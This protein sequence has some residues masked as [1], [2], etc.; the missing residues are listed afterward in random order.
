MLAFSP[1]T[2]T[3]YNIVLTALSLVAAI[4]L[5]GAGLAIAVEPGLVAS[6]WIGGAIVGGGIAA[7]HYTG[8]AAFEIP[9][10]IVWDPLLVAVSIALGAVLGAVSLRTGLAGNSMK[11]RVYGALLLT[12]AICSH[13]FTAMGAISILPDPAIEISKSSLPTSW[14][15]VAVATASVIIIV[16]AFAGLTL[17]FQQRRS[18]LEAEWMRRLAN[19]SVEALIVCNGD[20]IVTVNNSF[21]TLV[22][23][24]EALGARL[25][26]YL[27]DE[28]SRRTL[29]ERPN[30]PFE[31]GLLHSNGS[32]IPVEAILRVIDFAGMPHQAIAIRDL[33]ARKEA[34]HRVEQAER[35]LATVIDKAPVPIV[36]K[37]PATQKFVLVNRAYEQFA[38][39]CRVE[40]IGKTVHDLYPPLQAKEI[41]ELDEHAIQ[42]GREI[43]RELALDTV[44]GFHLA[45]TTRIV[46]RDKND[47]PQHLILAIEDVT[48]RARVEEKLR[49]QKLLTETAVSNMSQG[50]VMFDPQHR[51]VLCNSRY[52]EIY[53]MNPEVVR[54][55][56]T[57][58]E[59][60]DHRKEIG[61]FS[62]DPEKRARDIVA[63]VVQGQAWTEVLTLPNLRSIQKNTQP[64]PGGGWVA[65]HEDIT[66]RQLA[67]ERIKYMAHHDALTGLPNRTLLREQLD[68]HLSS[69][70]RGATLAIL[71]LDLDYFK[72]VND[73]LGHPIGDVLLCAVGKRLSECIRDS[74]FVA[75]LGGDE[76]AII[77]TD[78][79]QPTSASALAQRLVD[80]MATPFD[81]DGH[82]IIIGT[83]VGISIAP[84]DSMDPDILLK[85]ADMA[86]YRAKEHGRN[87]FSFFEAGMDTKM[88]ER[89][90]LEIDLRKAIAVGEF[91]LF[92]QPIMNLEHDTISGFEALLR[93]NHPTRGMVTPATFI[94]LAEDTGL[95]IPIGEWVLRQAC[96]EAAKWPDDIKVAVNL[97]PVQFRNRNLVS[98]V[99]SAVANSGIAAS[100]LELEITETIMLQ[101]SDATLAVLR[102]LKS[103]G[104]RISMD[105][106]GTGYSSLSYL[107]SFPFDKIK[108]DQCFVRDLD[109]GGEAIAIIHAVSGLGKSFGMMTTVE[110]IET[111]D[112]LER[113]RSEGCTEVQGYLFGKPQPASEVPRLL[114]GLGR[115]SQAAA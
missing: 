7:M 102:M 77:Q 22:G 62:G 107:R 78:V 33:R 2:P 110:G 31:A 47:K 3:A 40:L 71:C 12:A 93:W 73:T 30:Q 106:F 63:S 55:G 99:T 111:K 66:E 48:E 10:R 20:V 81:A 83:S 41:A 58:Q 19:V 26:K 45:K 90:T 101:N 68:Y 51:I 87:G 70:K 65:T 5:T 15:A 14:L 18:K 75:R 105:D 91:E 92:Y 82:E 25:E 4:L 97:S 104:V 13:H 44:G 112:Q 114:S 94:P 16:F 115:K 61:L 80:T 59:L 72:Q 54:P 57:L 37:D 50:L 96:T 95:I 52:I 8:M 69:V 38:G 85:S 24:E 76:F 46:V 39:K 1:G 56:C 103:L 23:D 49:E 43:S 36:V 108:I 60:N 79:E 89:R 88:H 28:T 35:F 34:E 84:N 74:D 53:N 109:K 27:P 9:G 6:A 100:R 32:I 98:I 17:D 29:L 11:W 64:L 21:V 86:L 113:V 42:S 67:E